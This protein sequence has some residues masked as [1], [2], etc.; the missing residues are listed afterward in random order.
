M[1]T[2]TCLEL[3]QTNGGLAFDQAY[4]KDNMIKPLAS[5]AIAGA[6][7]GYIFLG[8]KNLGTY[9]LAYGAGALT[10]KV[11]QSIVNQVF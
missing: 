4:L 9:A 5:G 10:Y 2:L 7:I 3:N 1:R 8:S 6:V 11:T